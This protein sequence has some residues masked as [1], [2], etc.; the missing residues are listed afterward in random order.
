MKKVLLMTS[1]FS[2]LGTIWGQYRGAFVENDFATMVFRANGVNGVPG[3]NGDPTRVLGFPPPN[4]TP[5]VPDNSK[6]F[7]FGWGGYVEVGFVRPVWNIPAGRDP[8]NPDGYDLI[9]FGNAFYTGSSLCRA[10][11]EPGY[12]EVG[13]DV[14]GNGVPDT[15]DRWYLLLPRSPDPRD[16]VGIP[17][18]PLS[19]SFFGNVDVCSVPFVGYADVTP[20]SNQ[21]HPLIPDD[22]YLPGL[23]N[24]SAGG[25]VLD[26]D[27]AIDWQTGESI[28]LARADFVRVAHAGNAVL[29]VLGRSSTEISAIALPRVPGDTNADGCVDDEDLLAVLFAFGT[30]DPIADVNRD[31]IVDDRDLLM[32]LFSFGF[33]CE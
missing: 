27:W 24:G 15:G 3:F 14:N 13:V 5:T 32:V 1:I 33:G 10:F 29:G 9:L 20:V 19:D 12:V 7:S 26:L 6:I 31:E 17:R 22:P 28:I 25:D 4:A 23:Q 16:G 30:D 11:V 2:L 8:L 21:G 18:F